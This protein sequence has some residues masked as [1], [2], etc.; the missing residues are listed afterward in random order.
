MM[1]G[2]SSGGAHVAPLDLDVLQP[3]DS[4]AVRAWLD[5]HSTREVAAELARLPP[6]ETAALLMPGKT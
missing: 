2:H 4:P 3:D 1:D 6:A 5:E